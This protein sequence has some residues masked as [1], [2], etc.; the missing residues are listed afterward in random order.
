MVSTS[1]ATRLEN[2]PTG[3]SDRIMSMRL[4]LKNKRHA[5]LFSVYVPTLQAEPA[6][7]DKFYSQLC[8]CLQSTPVDDKVIILGDF[9]AR[10]SQDADSWKGVFF[11]HGVGNC[12]DNGRLR[13]ELCTE[14]QLVITNSIFQQKNTDLEQPGCILGPNIGTSLT[15]SFLTSVISRTSFTPKGCQALNATPTIT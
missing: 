12:N 4:P 6:E 3:H 11:R 10:V 13:L 7:K 1:I 14:Q 8:S 9:N 15:T 5:T 2:L